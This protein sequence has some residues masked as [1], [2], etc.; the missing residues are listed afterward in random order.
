MQRRHFLQFGTASVA[1]LA[2]PVLRAQPLT[3]LKFTLDFRI[4]GQ[5]APFFVAL[6]RGYYEAEGLEPSFDVGSGSVAAITRVASG[7][8]DMGFGDISALIEFNASQPGAPLLQAVYQYYNRAPFVIIGRK[9]RGITQD[10]KSLQ[11]KRI[12]AAA[13][14]STRRAWPMAARHAGMKAEAIEWVTT[15]FSQRDNVIIRGDVDGAT[16]FHDS[17]LSLFQRIDPAQLSV[18]SYAEAGLNLYGNAILASTKLMADKPQAVRGFLKAT[19]RALL[20]C[21]AD[22]VAAMQYVKRREPMVDEK[23]EAERFRITAGYVANA[24]TRSHVLGDVRPE[25][26]RQQVA[27]V[28]Q[29]FALKQVPNADALYN[30]SFLPPKAE[31]TMKA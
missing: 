14:E 29:T 12:A 17:A 30:L 10:F 25:L 27:E 26:V 3:K 7:A 18:L 31:R 4:S 20:E 6:Y 15:D 23:V 16:Y 21:L 2:A 8:Y 19:N 11:G 1:G 28:S 5:V 9:D 24:D 22:P 13:V